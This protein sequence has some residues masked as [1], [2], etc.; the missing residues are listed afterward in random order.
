MLFPQQKAESSDEDEEV[1]LMIKPG[2]SSAKEEKEND[3]FFKKVSFCQ[4][5]QQSSSVNSSSLSSDTIAIYLQAKC[6][7][8]KVLGVNHH[9]IN[10]LRGLLM[11]SMPF[12]HHHTSHPRKSM[13]CVVCG[14]HVLE[15]FVVSTVCLC[16]PP[17]VTVTMCTL[18]C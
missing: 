12:P 13:I 8:S 17:R 16:S 18:S 3:A 2:S 10:P 11:P 1:S 7:P 15:Q 9:P 5:L 4:L 14:W 6:Q